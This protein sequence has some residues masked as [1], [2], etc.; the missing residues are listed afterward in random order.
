MD[1]P[2]DPIE[3]CKSCHLQSISNIC[4][5]R[6]RRINQTPT[7]EYYK[8]VDCVLWV[9]RVIEKNEAGIRVCPTCG[10]TLEP[11]PE[12]EKMEPSD[13]FGASPVVSP[14]YLLEQQKQ[15][16]CGMNDILDNIALSN[17]PIFEDQVDHVMA[18]AVFDWGDSQVLPTESIFID[19]AGPITKEAMDA[20]S[21]VKPPKKRGFK[22]IPKA[23]HKKAKE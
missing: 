3:Q 23:R 5:G 17:P 7:G 16:N 15:I 19:E 18:G 11:I 8:T 9:E 2:Q 1:R 21:P 10:H 13:S 4:G 12:P 22:D 14:E 6:K 20:L